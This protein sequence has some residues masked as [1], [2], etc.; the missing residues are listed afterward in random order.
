LFL[1][2]IEFINFSLF[3]VVKTILKQ[4]ISIKNYAFIFLFFFL[5]L[6]ILVSNLIGLTPYSITITSHLIFTLYYSLAFFIGTNLIGFL[7][8]RENYFALFLP[9]DIPLAIIPLFIL[10]EYLGHFSK[11]LTLSIRLF[12]NMMSGHI[13]L[14]ILIKL[15]WSITTAGSL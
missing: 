7:Y 14:K 11:I 2:S 13:L 10:I 15:V 6:F 12:A 5:F 3:N 9:D 8:Q 1:N 4:Y